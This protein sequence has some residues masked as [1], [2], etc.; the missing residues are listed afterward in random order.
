MTAGDWET[1][2]TETAN[3][4]TVDFQPGSGVVWMIKNIAT[5]GAWELYWTDGTNYELI[6]HGRSATVLD[7]LELIADNDNYYYLK[8]VSGSTTACGGAYVVLK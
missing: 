2:K 8:N 6:K 5:G 7:K 3:N 4:G 1:I